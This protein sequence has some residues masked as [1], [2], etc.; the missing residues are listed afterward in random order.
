MQPSDPKPRRKSPTNVRIRSKA[1]NGRLKCERGESSESSSRSREPFSWWR[2]ARPVYSSPSF[3]RHSLAHLRA[4]KELQ[5]SW[6]NARDHENGRP[7][8][9][10]AS[11]GAARTESNVISIMKPRGAAPGCAAI[12]A[13]GNR[14]PANRGRSKWAAAAAGLV[15]LIVAGL[16]VAALHLPASRSQEYYATRIGEQRT[17]RLSDGSTLRLDGD[18]RIRVRI[19]GHERRVDLLAGQVLFKVAKDVARPF[20]VV[21]NGTRIRDIGTQFDVNQFHSESIVAVLEGRVEV[22]G[23]CSPPI[24]L[25]AG[26]QVVMTCNAIPRREPAN[27]TATTAWTRDE[28][29][30]DSTPLAQAAV[31]FNRFN[32]RQLVI[33]GTQLQSFQIGGV[34]PALDPGA[35]PRF[36]QFLRRARPGVQVT[37]AGDRI[38]VT[39]E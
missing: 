11:I 35:L 15:V 4:H 36:V 13:K 27:I 20:V 2:S 28:L 5:R 21:S 34:F 38:I 10:G 8:D 14:A 22:T 33:K 25:G 6:E 17:V 18:S 9:V 12:A 39:E 32:A 1:A 24:E 37:E 16:L 19:D 30:F 29:I 3:L 7:I 31:E 26:Q 23:P